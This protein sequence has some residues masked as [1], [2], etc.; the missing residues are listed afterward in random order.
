MNIFRKLFKSTEIQTNYDHIMTPIR[1]AIPGQTSSNFKFEFTQKLFG[2]YSNGNLFIFTPANAFFQHTSTLTNNKDR[3][4]QITAN[5]DR[6]LQMRAMQIFKNF[7]F[8]FTSIISKKEGIY[9]QAELNC[10]NK[11]NAISLKLLSPTFI[12]TKPIYVFNI[13]QN[14]NQY[15]SLGTELVYSQDKKNVGINVAAKI[16]TE[17]CCGVVLLQ[18]S[19]N[20]CIGALKKI[21]DFFT[22]ATEVSCEKSDKNW[23]Q[24]IVA[25][26]GLLLETHKSTVKVGIF[27]DMISRIQIREKL[28][29]NLALGID[30]ELNHA[31]DTQALGISFSL[32][33]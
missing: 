15:L 23:P 16:E 26:L 9:S 17:K 31:N 22:I 18:Q 4:L 2:S 27:S 21:N 10:K 5:Q 7:T 30:G 33:N 6:S 19:S 11:T 29:E 25:N 13:L 32:D 20:L 3:L 12:D 24:N 1:C 8:D 28:A 14:L